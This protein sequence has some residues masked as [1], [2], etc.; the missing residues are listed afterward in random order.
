VGSKQLAVARGRQ[1]NK[2]DWER[3]VKKPK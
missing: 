2:D 3:P 1:V